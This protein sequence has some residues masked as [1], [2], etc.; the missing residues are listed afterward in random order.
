MTAPALHARGLVKLRGETQVVAGVDLTLHAGESAALVGSSGCG[1]TTLLHM[2]GV[3]DRPS[4]G[5]VEIAGHD[6]WAGDAAFQAALRLRC[7]GFVFQQSNLLPQLT[8]EENIALPAWRLTG[9]RAAALTRARELGRRFGLDRR[10]QARAFQL[11][12]GEAQR[13]AVARALINQ[14]ALLFADEPTGS[15]DSESSA[16]VVQALQDAARDGAAML[17]VTHDRE[18][19]RSFGRTIHMKDGRITD[20]PSIPV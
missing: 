13:T 16:I 8:I 1:K 20:L 14:P 2:L 3:L 10:L 7:I 17:V 15:L 5:R 4:A 19:A 9:D 11:S 6:P 12:L 18:V